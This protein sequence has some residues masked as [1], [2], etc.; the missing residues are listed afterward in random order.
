MRAR[1][2]TVPSRGGHLSILEAIILGVVQGLTEFLPISSS[3]HL[4]LAGNLFGLINA[5]TS[6][7]WTAF[8]AVIQLGTLLAV[9]VFFSKDLILMTRSLFSD[10]RLHKSVVG[11]YA[12]P[13]RLAL[14]VIFGTVPIVIIGLGFSG[15]IHSMFTKST[16][17]IASSLIGLAVLLF[18]AEKVAAHKR[19]LEQMTFVDALVIG[20]AQA[21]ALIP[22]SSR[23][24]TTITAGLFLN[25]QREAAARFSF[26]LSIPAVAA[27]GLYELAKL[28]G[29]IAG[30]GYANLIA[31]TV[32][33]AV[34]GYASIAWLLKFLARHTTFV[35][36]AY[37]IM[38]GILL[39]VLLQVG[40]FRF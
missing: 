2:H 23:S 40:F 11:S 14:Y 6:E 4:T 28:Q 18:L 8:I 19:T 32:A 5:E 22:G 3:A 7:A 10:M 24:G 16:T 30:F 36:I 31:A 35:F 27:S 21:M 12:Q 25:L 17:V 33:S 39:L 38:L 13:S 15:F 1:A 9:V 20:T 34:V 37:R 26:L 29:D